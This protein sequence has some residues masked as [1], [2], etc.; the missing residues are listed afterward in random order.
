MPSLRTGQ[1]SIAGPPSNLKLISPYPAQ[2]TEQR[3]DPGAEYRQ[4]EAEA[5]ELLQSCKRHV[6]KVTTAVRE[7]DALSLG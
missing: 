6:M 5:Q 2:F 4:A 3:A 1:H 7:L